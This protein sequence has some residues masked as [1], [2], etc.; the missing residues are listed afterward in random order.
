M[1]LMKGEGGVA[2][3][4]ASMSDD[5]ARLLIKKIVVHYGRVAEALGE[6]RS[7]RIVR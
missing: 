4:T 5:D 3:T 7:S 1:R 6:Q 2:A